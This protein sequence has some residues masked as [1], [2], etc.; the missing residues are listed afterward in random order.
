MMRQKDG[1]GAIRAAALAGVFLLFQGCSSGSGGSDVGHRE[2]IAPTARAQLLN[3]GENGTYREGS[4]VLLS[5]K[6]SEDGDGPLLDWAWRQT[7]G[8]AVRLIERNQTTM[9]FTAPPVSADTKLTFELTVEDTDHLTGTASIDVH[10]TPARDPDKFLSLDVRG[11]TRNTFDRFQVVPALAEGAST[12][13]TP[14][15]FTLSA[16]AY[17]IYPP[18]S[19]PNIDCA[20]DAAEF[21]A[22]VPTQT[23][24]GCLVALLQDLTPTPLPGG[25][26]GIQGEWPANVPK[27]VRPSGLTADQLKAEWWNPHYTLEIPRL[28]VADF[29]QQFVDSGDR[30]RMLDLF[31]TAKTHI[32]LIFE[33]AAPENQQDATLIVNDVESAPITE[34]PTGSPKHV[35]GEAKVVDNSGAGLPTRAVLPL[36]RVLG[37]IVGRES[38]LTAEVYYQTVDPQFTR[39]TLNDWLLQAGFASDAAGT[40]KPGVRE[41]TGEFAHVVYL[42]NYDLGFGRD[43]Y[44]RTDEFGNVFAFVGNYS[45]LEGAIRKSSPIATVVM[46]YSPLNAASD[47]TEKFVKFFTYIDDGAGNARRVTSM[48]FDGRGEIFTPGNCLA[49]HGGAKPPGASELVFDAACGNTDD[50][51][52]YTWP[53]TNRDGVEI[54]NGNLHATFLPWDANALLFADTDPAITNAPVRFDGISLLDRL[55]RD[56]GDFTRAAQEPEIKKVNEAA[57]ATYCNAAQVPDCITDAARRLVEHWYGGVDRN[58]AL[59][60]A[61]F[62]DSTAVEG[63]KNGETVPDPANAGATVTNPDDAEGLYHDVYAQHCRMCHTNIFDPTLRFDTYQKLAAQKSLIQDR[64][65]K[66]GVMPL[67]RLTMDRLWA[68]QDG[69]PVPAHALAAHLAIPD[70]VAVPPAPEAQIGQPPSATVTRRGTVRLSAYESN[71]ATA[72]A[73]QIGYEPPAE[74]AGSAGVA[75][76]A[77]ELI[78]NGTPEIAFVPE[79]PGTYTA[80]LVINGADPAAPPAE[81]TASRSVDVQNFTPLACNDSASTTP[82]GS[83]VVIEFLKNDRFE[84]SGSGAVCGDADLL[85]VA[86]SPDV[87]VTYMFSESFGQ[88]GQL[89]TPHSGT[90]TLDPGEPCAPETPA[91]CADDT[92]TYTPNGGGDS[93]FDNLAYTL[94]DADGEVSGSGIITVNVTAGLVV[95]ANGVSNP[96]SEKQATLNLSISGGALG[97]PGQ[98]Y[99]VKLTG[100]PARGVVSHNGTAMAAGSS[101]QTDT[102]PSFTYV[103]NAFATGAESITFTVT[104]SASASHA[105]T[106]NFTVLPQAPF[107]VPPG[108][109]LPGQIGAVM[110]QWTADGFADNDSG[111]TGKIDCTSCHGFAGDG[112][113]ATLDAADVFNLIDLSNVSF[114][115]NEL[116][117]GTAGAAGSP[118]RVKVLLS[119]PDSSIILCYPS[120]PVNTDSCP[121]SPILQPAGTPHDGGQALPSGSNSYKIIKRWIQEGANFN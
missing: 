2:E 44:T 7:A 47:P 35:Q 89:T 46:E 57:H 75:G 119:A 18:R 61:K 58:G 117:N 81:L 49:C 76:Y 101:F 115:Y 94:T 4:E 62:D 9:S 54:A 90:F 17:L 21:A 23:A 70:D 20:F 31:N 19:T 110:A 52:C 95:T 83:A 22:G 10:V 43:M 38:A 100:A 106:F 79:K 1:L 107:R 53:T 65:F 67:A 85:A 16:R 120:S 64:V 8:P 60:A 42:N 104:D 111:N 15:P 3:G 113:S 105:G 26:T 80:S 82:G 92:L 77:P 69:S 116:V 103:S 114:I 34:P 84:V 66:D 71:F 13:A 109:L 27:V 39:F 88:N 118:S 74:L 45:T 73:W 5:G 72:Y 33:L 51:F 30:S 108:G 63:W 86:N 24:T 6:D 112:N 29:N 78:G 102:S 121:N 55:K 50:A 32:A 14:K 41:G 37:G 93:Y 97:N 11:A 96:V 28:D 87:P 99:T 25:G 40:L 36:E 48:N 59:V 68:P 98:R 91:G 12:G 56:Y